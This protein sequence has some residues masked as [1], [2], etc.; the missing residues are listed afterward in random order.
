MVYFTQAYGQDTGHR[1]E[2]MYQKEYIAINQ[3]EKKGLSMTSLY[4]TVPYEHKYYG[5]S[6]RKIYQLIE[7]IKFHINDITRKITPN[8]AGFGSISIDGVLATFLCINELESLSHTFYIK[9]SWNVKLCLLNIFGQ[10]KKCL[11]HC[12]IKFS[13]SLGLSKDFISASHQ[14]KSLKK[15]N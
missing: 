3:I 1:T 11:F 9:I 12:V 8:F 5:V 6:N 15:F 13:P 7:S 2:S 4:I 14:Y 10:K